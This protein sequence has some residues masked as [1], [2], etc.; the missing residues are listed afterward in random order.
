MAFGLSFAEVVHQ[1]RSKVLALGIKVLF[2][3]TGPRRALSVQMGRGPGRGPTD[4]C[5]PEPT[6]LPMLRTLKYGIA[7][8]IKRHPRTMAAVWDIL[9]R[10][11]FALPHDRSYLGFRQ[12][13]NERSGLFL[14]VG[15]NNGISAAGFRKLNRHYDIFSLE[16]SIWHEPALMAMKKR[17]SDFDYR[18][19]AAGAEAGMLNLITPFYG[20]TPLHAH[21]STSMEYLEISLGR[22][23]SPRVVKKITY[24]ERQVEVV[25]VDEL[26]LQ[27]SIVKIDVEGCDYDVLLGMRDTIQRCRPYLLVEFTPA[28]MKDF[29]EFFQQRRYV[30]FTYDVR[31]DAFRRFDL[32]SATRDWESDHLQVNIYCV[33]EEQ[34]ASLG[35]ARP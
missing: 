9:P 12:I 15:A 21:A 1:L 32:T 10:V 34:L 5:D 8:E 25:P 30:M 28:H 13:A 24:R 3:D 16:A 11:G 18:I 4:E 33:A 17:I 27:P 14:D 6:I 7:A 20:D 19:V 31:D 29:F 2:L 26:A 23:Y 22:D 35:L